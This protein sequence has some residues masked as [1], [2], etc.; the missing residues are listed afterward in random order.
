MLSRLLRC[1]A[2]VLVVLS[3]SLPFAAGQNQNQG[4][5][6]IE[7]GVSKD[8]AAADDEASNSSSSVLPHFVMA[9]YTLA[10]LTI[11]CMPSRKA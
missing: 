11:V 2:A 4:L 10:V 1:F 7:R 3:L 5:P 6:T 9:V 8:A